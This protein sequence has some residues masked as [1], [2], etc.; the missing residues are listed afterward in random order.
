[1]KKFLVFCWLIGFINI[2]SAQKISVTVSAA[3]GPMENYAAKELC[4]YVNGVSGQLPGISNKINNN[5]FIIG[6]AGKD[7]A[8][9]QFINGE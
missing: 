5:G 6:V 7:K 2:A 9:D 1:M 8:I 3:A 4:R